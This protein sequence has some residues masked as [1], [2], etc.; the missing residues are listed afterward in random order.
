MQAE[1][2]QSISVYHVDNVT[3][4]CPSMWQ[5]HWES[6]PCI[7]STKN[8]KTSFVVFS[9][10]A[11]LVYTLKLAALWALKWKKYWKQSF[12][13]QNK[14]STEQSKT[15]KLLSSHYVVSLS[16]LWQLFANNLGKYGEYT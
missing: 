15:M 1:E 9:A 5:N 3:C 16:L 8:W 2:A 7:P 10:T 13:W 11:A 6:S 4:W 12:P 14:S